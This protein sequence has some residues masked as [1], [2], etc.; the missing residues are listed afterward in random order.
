M[1]DRGRTRKKHREYR[2]VRGKKVRKR[3]ED[4]D[5]KEKQNHNYIAS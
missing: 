4:D 3:S 5:I 1:R 2:G